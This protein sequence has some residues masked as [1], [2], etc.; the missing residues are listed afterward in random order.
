M[1]AQTLLKAGSKA[2]KEGALV[3]DVIKSTLKIPVGAFLGVTVDQ[4]ASTL[5]EMQNN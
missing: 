1:G 4:V 2:I 3:K 5:N